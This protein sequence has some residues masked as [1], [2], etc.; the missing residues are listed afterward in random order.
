MTLDAARGLLACPHCARPLTT[1]DAPGPVHCP[2]G[3]SFDVAKQGYLNLLGARPPA[4]ADTADMLTARDRVLASGLFNPIADQ[5]AKR[6]A[7]CST[8]AEIGAGTGFYLARCLDAS[9]GRG[10]A[11]DVSVAAARRAARAHERGASIV[12]D[13]WGS[14]PILSGRLAGLLCVFAPRNVAEFARVLGPNGLL[15]VVTPTA[16]HLEGL[17]QRYGLLAI[18]PDKDARLARSMLGHFVGIANVGLDYEVEASAS[19]V[20]DL[21]A[22]GPNAFHAVPESVHDER[23]RISVTVSL[24]RKQDAAGLTLE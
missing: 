14:L 6:L 8:I 7:S 1:S 2:S 23:V 11:L 10:I 5:V 24:F 19:V 15:V 3:H 13:A 21:I 16:S 18:E 20:R 4:N 12:A 22:M 17:R 9:S